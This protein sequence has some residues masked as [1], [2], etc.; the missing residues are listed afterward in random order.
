[1]EAMSNHID[2]VLEIN[3]RN[4]ALYVSPA[5]TEER[6]RY[7]DRHPTE[8]CFLKCM[9]GRVHGPV[10][11]QTPLGIIQPFRNLGGRFDLGWPVFQH[12]F[13]SWRTYA[14]R[15]RRDCL[16]I[17]T[18]H[19]SRSNPHWGCAGFNY[20]TPAAFAFTGNLRREFIED[21]GQ[22]DALYTIQ[23]GI[24]TD[25]DALI[26]HGEQGE[27]IDMAEVTDASESHLVALLRGLYPK[28][29]A[30]MVADFLPLLQGNIA[31]IAEVRR[32]SRPP[33]ELQHKEWILAVGR[34]FDWLHEINQALIV[35]PFDL[36]HMADA[37]VVAGKVLL[38]N[39]EQGR[40]Q[41]SPNNGIVLL[42]CVPYF[43]PAGSEPRQAARK[44]K[45]LANL[46]ST[47]TQ[48]ELPLLV[49]HI[50]RLTGTVDQ[51]TRRFNVLERD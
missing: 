19:F 12:T 27:R 25:L 3:R 47:A 42:T 40:I 5:V 15:K 48:K 18:Y 26:L 33:L 22:S 50:Q 34:G 11:T 41:V 36:E 10:I 20:D 49:P 32:Q 46:A 13:K 28:M 37:I 51:S 21:F 23:C 2:D 38:S 31:H 8:I 45:Y 39:I 9:D 44:A 4:S 6:T 17:V 1:M 35:G 14:R 29:S 30:Q 16:A 24:E 43:E 7:R